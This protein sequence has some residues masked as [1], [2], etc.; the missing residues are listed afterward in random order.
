MKRAFSTRE[1][2]LLVILAVM[3]LMI[4][5]F[6]LVL[7]PINNRI[8]DVQSQMN[9]EQSLIDI[10]N[11]RLLKL[12][13]MEKELDKIKDSGEAQPLP[14]FD[15]KAQILQELSGLLSDSAD[16]T[17]TFGTATTI[18]DYVL[19]RPLK[20]SFTAESYDQ[21][22]SILA[23]LHKS[24]NINQISDISFVFNNDDRVNV[25]LSITY[26]EL[27]KG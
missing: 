6:K 14:E 5:Y 9:A 23:A 16:Y 8:A 12:K 13:Q 15:N 2:I 21:A 1:K 11:V 10:N 3:L 22:S 27:K 20:L 26:F 18:N 24:S 25:T 7:E 19:C 4:G 17:L